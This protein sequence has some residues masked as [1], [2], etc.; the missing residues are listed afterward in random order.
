M[1]EIKRQHIL[2]VGNKIGLVFSLSKLRTDAQSYIASVLVRTI[3]NWG[4]IIFYKKKI[5]IVISSVFL[6]TNI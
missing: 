1:I 5:T 3:H 6:I 2:R 4:I